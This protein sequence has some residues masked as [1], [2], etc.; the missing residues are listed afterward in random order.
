MKASLFALWAI[1]A[2]PA[3]AQEL[4][5]VN[6]EPITKDTLKQASEAMGPR[7]EQVLENPELRRQLLDHMID[8]RLAARAA[9]KAGL[10][11]QKEFKDQLEEAR[12]QIL[13][14]LYMKRY[15]A[16]RTTPADVKAFFTKDPTRFSLKEIHVQHV[17]VKSEDEAKSVLKDALA[18]KDF[19]ELARTHSAGPSA[20][21]GGDL[22]FFHRGRMV[23]E[24]EAAAFHTAKGEIYPKPV[25][26][27]FGWHVI[28][29]LDERGSDEV[30]FEEAKERVLEALELEVRAEMQ[31]ALRAKAKVSINEDALKRL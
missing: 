30:R 29:V 6:G 27:V 17:L 9:E 23:P 1:F 16:D 18:G 22:G 14:S 11:K 3:A 10:E 2:T 12:R 5:K 26:T 24:F 19:A 21:K 15:V 7:G 8:S 20:P 13:S 28:K 4:A 25:K 31:T